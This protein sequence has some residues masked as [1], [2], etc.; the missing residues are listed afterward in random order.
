V[1]FLFWQGNGGELRWRLG[2]GALLLTFCCRTRSSKYSKFVIEET[3]TISSVH[4]L[5][6]WSDTNTIALAP[7]LGLNVFFGMLYFLFEFIAFS[8]CLLQCESSNVRLMY[9]PLLVVH[10]ECIS[11][12]FLGVPDLSFLNK[13]V[14]LAYLRGVWKNCT[15]VLVGFQRNLTNFRLLRFFYI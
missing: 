4:V 8:H 10:G 15:V 12:N 7:S 1:F 3:N 5:M 2:S 11:L 13:N 9:Y 14:R 6:K